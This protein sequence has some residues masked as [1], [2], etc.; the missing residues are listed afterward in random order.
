MLA[1]GVKLGDD[2]TTGIET[3]TEFDARPSGT[4]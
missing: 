4:V 3:N 1:D 2:I